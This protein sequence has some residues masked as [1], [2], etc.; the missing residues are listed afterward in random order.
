MPNAP[1]AFFKLQ[2]LFTQKHALLFGVFTKADCMP[3]LPIVDE[4]ISSEGN[5]HMVFT[6]LC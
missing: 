5:A 1:K 4:N 3:A 2:N 6:F